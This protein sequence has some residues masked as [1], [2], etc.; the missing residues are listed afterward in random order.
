M[1]PDYRIYITWHYSFAV[2]SATMSKDQEG[3]WRGGCRNYPF[4]RFCQCVGYKREESS[5][6][7][8]NCGCVARCHV[9]KLFNFCQRKYLTKIF[10]WDT[11]IYLPKKFAFCGIQVHID[12]IKFALLRI[13]VC[14]LWSSSLLQKNQV[15]VSKES[16][17]HRMSQ[18]LRS[19]KLWS[20]SQLWTQ[21]KQVKFCKCV[22][23]PSS[24]VR[25]FFDSWEAETAAT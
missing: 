8:G 18:F 2:Q 23:A 1:K 11:L 17:L 22:W 3:K 12:W 10:S 14:V 9:G 7:S 25:V 13:Q 20:W 24:T 16:S 15:W 5:N 4:H 19:S 21:F 6:K